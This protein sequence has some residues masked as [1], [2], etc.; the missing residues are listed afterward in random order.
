MTGMVNRITTNAMTW[1][2]PTIP[3]TVPY[4]RPLSRMRPTTRL[5][6][7][8][9]IAPPKPTSPATDATMRRSKRS[10][11]TIITSVDH[12]CWPKKATLK[13]TIARLVGAYVTNTMSGMRAALAPSAA[14][15]DTLTEA[16]R[17]SNQLENHPPARHPTPAAAYG[18]Q[19]YAP[20][21][22]TSK[23]LTSY[24][25]FGSQNKQKYQAA[26]LRNF[27]TTSPHTSRNPIR[28]LQGRGASVLDAVRGT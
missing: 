21:R 7:T 22:F 9:P 27:A 20:T 19:A 24:R 10:V 14:L 1:N 25:Y 2:V 5:K 17:F 8:P 26:S 28:R 11:G 13:S 15:R 3:N 12:D 18:I 16:P 6:T 4:P 23:P